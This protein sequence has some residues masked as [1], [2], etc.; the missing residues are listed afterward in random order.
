MVLTGKGEPVRGGGTRTLCARELGGRGTDWK[1]SLGRRRL[2]LSR[3][4]LA[5]PEMGLE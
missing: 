2:A 1:G 5:L 4:W 3:T